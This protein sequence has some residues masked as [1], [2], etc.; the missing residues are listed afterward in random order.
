[1]HYHMNNFELC[2]IP[3]DLIQEESN[4]S[5][6]EVFDDMLT[7]IYYEGYAKQ[8]ADENPEYYTSE[9]YYFRLLYN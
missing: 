3:D 2:V 1:M 7:D 9:F 4:E 8:L 5:L 6:R